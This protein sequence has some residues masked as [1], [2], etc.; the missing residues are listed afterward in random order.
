MNM[1]YCPRCRAS[2]WVDF[3]GLRFMFVRHKHT[4]SIRKWQCPKC[5]FYIPGRIA[6]SATSI[7]EAV[8]WQKQFDELVSE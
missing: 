1:L 6:I 5:S 4:G 8:E 3:K 2:E 7:E